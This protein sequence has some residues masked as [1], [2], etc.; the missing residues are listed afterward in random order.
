MTE[1]QLVDWDFVLDTIRD[2]RCILFIGPEVFA[3]PE[4]I[5]L[6]TQLARYLGVPENPDIQKYYPD[7]ALFFFQ[8]GAKKTRISYSIKRFYHQP[9][10]H[11]EAILEQLSDI[12]FHFIISLTPDQ[13]LQS[14]FDKK[15][16]KY[17]SDY[18]YKNQPADPEAKIPTAANPL[19]YNLLGSVDVQESLILTH[20]D[21]YD[22]F[23]SIFR[24][25]S[26]PETYKNHLRQARNFI[27]I[28]LQF[29]KWYMQLLLRILY[30]HNDKAEFM[31]YA[32]SEGIEDEVKT[33]CLE[34]FNINFISKDIPTFVGEL[35][36]H[37]V[38]AGLLRN[39][40]DPS[41][42]PVAKWIGLLAKGNID[43]VL[44][45]FAVYLERS[46]NAGQVLYNDVLNLMGRWSMLQQKTNRGTI[47]EQDASVETNKVRESLLDLLNAAK[48][49][50]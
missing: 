8:S 41:V 17:K 48:T 27:F 43:T 35:H 18:Y 9:S 25:K 1:E 49:T 38:E 33:L 2:E 5:N 6:E 34:Q 19:I 37:C 24:G 4:G 40:N 30:L 16:L 42:S 39:A 13:L 47:G 31:R 7:D 20:D 3:T 32:A 46:G 26:I 44:D 14:I 21:L 36:R 12:P 15:N 29:D 45:E 28:G 10:P 50:L 11:A 23:E 22:Y